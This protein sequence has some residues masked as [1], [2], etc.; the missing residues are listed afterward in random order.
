MPLKTGTIEEPELNL[1]PMIDIVFLLIIFFMTTAQFARLTREHVD[2]PQERGEQL[3]D[4]EDPGVVVNL[5]A[6][7]RIVVAGETVD[8]PG[9]E[10]IVRNEIE[11]V[12]GRDAA[13]VRI[14]IRADRNDDSA[15][16][17]R[18]VGR[19]HDLGVGAAGV[20]T[21]VPR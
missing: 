16:L 8:L 7:G 18:V 13:R 9:L 5:T 17:N 2:L 6:D 11:L 20:A 15:Q 19:L 10:A 4:P 1:T 21:E 3:E 14:M 12:E